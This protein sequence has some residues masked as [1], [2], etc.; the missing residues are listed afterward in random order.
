MD[1]N[2]SLYHKFIA[3]KTKDRVPDSDLPLRFLKFG[4]N[5]RYERGRNVYKRAILKCGLLGFK[6][7]DSCSKSLQEFKKLFTYFV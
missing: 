2:Q 3:I 6:A 5:F 7:I 1:G 4:F